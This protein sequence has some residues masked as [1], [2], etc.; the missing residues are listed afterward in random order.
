MATAGVPSGTILAVLEIFKGR[1]VFIFILFFLS[2]E[3]LQ[4]R[5]L[6]SFL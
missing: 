3:I 2:Q 1:Q 4:I 5:V 6:L